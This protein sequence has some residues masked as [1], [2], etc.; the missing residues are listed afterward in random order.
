M[1]GY[2]PH[3][4][5][6]RHHT[7]LACAHPFAS[8]LQL[9]PRCVDDYWAMIPAAYSIVIYP[10]HVVNSVRFPIRVV[11]FSAATAAFFLTDDLL[12][13]LAEHTILPFMI[14]AAAGI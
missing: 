10:C 5:T 1:L 13:Q 12:L 2:S 8:E 6:T 3:V 11:R 9:L 7:P 4:F 14:S